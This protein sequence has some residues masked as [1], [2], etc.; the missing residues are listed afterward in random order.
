MVSDQYGCV[1]RDTI[2]VKIFDLPSIDLGSDLQLSAND[3]VILDAGTGYTSYYWN[4]GEHSQKIKINASD[5]TLG[6]HNITVSV[7]DTNECFNTDLLTL[8]ILPSLG[9]NEFGIFPVP[10]H[11]V[12]NVISNQNLSGSKPV[13]IDI[14]GKNYYPGFTIVN[15]KMLINRGVIPEGTYFLFLESNG[16]LNSVGKLVID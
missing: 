2:N 11:D 3:S 8:T 4:T 7:I 12:L 16:K 5:Y 15:S 9:L 13:F 10:F 14:L 1:G 6:Q